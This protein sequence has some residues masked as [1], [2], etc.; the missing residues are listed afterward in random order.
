M[1][2]FSIFI[3]VTESNKYNFKKILTYRDFLGG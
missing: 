3:T 1:W 2:E